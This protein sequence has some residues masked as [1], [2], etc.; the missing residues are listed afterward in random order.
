M[1]SVGM[2]SGTLNLRVCWLDHGLPPGPDPQLLSTPNSSLPHPQ[3]C[4]I[5]CQQAPDCEVGIVWLHCWP[6]ACRLSPESCLGAA[7]LTPADIQ[8]AAPS[9]STAGSPALR[10]ALWPTRRCSSATSSASP[11]PPTTPG[12]PAGVQRCSHVSRVAVVVG[13]RRLRAALLA[14]SGRS[15]SCQL[16]R[17]PCLAPVLPLPTAMLQRGPG[18]AVQLHQ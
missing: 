1:A 13:R 8:L 18:G 11:A 10:R 3:D 14:G 12:E 6:T 15:M 17:P 4:M 7:P 5:A 9:H 16:T 2:G